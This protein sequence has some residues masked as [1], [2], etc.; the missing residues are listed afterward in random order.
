M[1]GRVLTGAAAA[2]AVALLVLPAAS[3]HAYLEAG[4]TV[5]GPDTHAE[6]GTK[7]IHLVFTENIEHQFTGA[8][9]L[10]QDGRRVDTGERTFPPDQA[11]AM[12]VPV[13]PLADGYFTVE[14]HTLSVDT[15][16]AQGSYLFAVGNA[17]L[18]CAPPA[19][20]SHQHGGGG[21]VPAWSEPVANTFVFAGVTLAAGL[22]FFALVVDRQRHR[23]HRLAAVGIVAAAAGSVAAFVRLTAFAGTIPTSLW[24]A[25][26]ATK[27][28][29][30]LAAEAIGLAVAAVALWWAYDVASRRAWRIAAA[31]GLLALLGT[32]MASHASALV[33]DRW[34]ALLADILHLGAAAVWIGG[35]AGFVLT[36]PGRRMADTAALVRRFS[37]WA[38]GSV[39]VL[40][41]SGTYASLRHL[42]AWSDLWLTDYGRDVLLKVL[43]L[44]ALG[45]LGA[46][47]QRRAGPALATGHDVRKQLQRSVTAEALLL[48]AVLVVTGLLTTAA[49][50]GAASPSTAAPDLDIPLRSMHV[51]ATVSPQPVHLGEQRFTVQVHPL[52]KASWGDAI[53]VYLKFQAP[54]AGPPTDLV[55][56]DR[57]SDIQ[58]S[59]CGGKLTT[60]GTW[61]VHVVVQTPEERADLPFNVTVG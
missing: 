42:V 8:S 53:T 16:T 28:G 25:A 46:W 38:M 58:W 11:N 12:D 6:R 30:W 29:P 32:S 2:L 23:S 44:V 22:A 35:I 55:A 4:L 39:G 52:Q 61:I 7:V 15:H 13:P 19:T 36:L 41:A 18:A 51:V 9:V 47:N 26:T 50:P 37:P 3:A 60:K 43:I 45:A 27:T 48:A 40:I 24:T 31:A 10:D 57:A 17:T 59:L 14:W 21:G 56:P 54:G 20:A 5:P 33:A 1:Q 49:P 34:L